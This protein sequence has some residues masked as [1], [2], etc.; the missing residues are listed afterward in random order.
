MRHIL[1]RLKPIFSV[2]FQFLCKFL[3]VGGAFGFL[4]EKIWNYHYKTYFQQ[5]LDSLRHEKRKFSR[6]NET[7]VLHVAQS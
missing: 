4:S 2:F 1:S 6:H 7:K 5:Y 3:E